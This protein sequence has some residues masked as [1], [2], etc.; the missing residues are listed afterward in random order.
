[1]AGGETFTLLD[2]D[3]LLA[4][5]AIITACVGFY[6]AR[7]SIVNVKALENRVKALEDE[8]KTLKAQVTELTNENRELHEQNDVLAGVN[9][10]YR[11][12][13]L[14]AMRGKRAGA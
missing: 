14:P 11:E 8:N 9:K 5:A 2:A 4:V 12:Q 6:K 13:L 1:M 3:T 10:E 7:L